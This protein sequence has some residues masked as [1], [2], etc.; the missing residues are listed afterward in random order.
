M[1][2]RDYYEILGLAKNAS[3]D[4]IKKAYRTA[5]MKYHPDRNKE[6]GAEEKFKEAKE[7]YECLSDLEKKQQYDQHGHNDPFAHGRR[8]TWHFN[9]GDE[10]I[11]NVFNNIFSGRGFQFN[12]DPFG[13]QAQPQQVLHIITI[14]LVDA[15]TG[16]TIKPDAKTII[17][18]PKGVRSG[19]RFFAEGKLFRVDVHQH[20][21]FKRALDDLMVNVEITAFEAIL[22]VEA[23]L[24]HLDGS[25]LQ[26]SIPPGIQN[27]QIIKLSG[28]GMKNP[29][30]DRCGDMM[31]RISIMVPRDLSEEQKTVLKTFSHRDS[32][33][34]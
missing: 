15:Y 14:S 27:D 3:D 31:V 21:K 13:Q 24:E 16:R 22:G 1:S 34:I 8:Q 19:T 4:D 29:E 9:T 2:K 12:A 11:S 20:E 17:N 10:H 25:K 33:N 28:K 7:A 18:I 23:I 5:A 6:P 32:I 26:F 30:T